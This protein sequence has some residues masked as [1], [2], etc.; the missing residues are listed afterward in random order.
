MGSGTRHVDRYKTE[1]L[2][3][4]SSGNTT[5]LWIDMELFS[6]VTFFSAV[7]NSTGVTGAAI[8]V[9]QAITTAGTSCPPTRRKR[10]RRTP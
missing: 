2:L 4:A 10:R 8:T 1:L 7:A 9:N 6:H 5:T 3:V